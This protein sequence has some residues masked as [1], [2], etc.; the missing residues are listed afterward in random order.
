[1]NR[2]SRAG[3]KGDFVRPAILPDWWEDSCEQDPRLLPEIEIRIARFLGLP[4]L[5]VKDVN[6][7]LAPASYPAVQLRGARVTDPKRLGPAIHSA[8]RIAAAVVRN[9]RDT[10]SGPNVPPSNGL[11]W[12]DQ[13]SRDH[14]A[15]ALK[16]IVL[17]LWKRGIPVIPLEVLP[18]PSFQGIACIVEGRPCIVVGHKHDEPGRVA[19]LVA[20]EVGHIALGD[21][22]PDQPVVDEDVEIDLEVNIERCADD[23]AMQ[24]LIGDHSVPEISGFSFKDLAQEASKIEHENGADAS[25]VILAWARRTGDYQK[26]T[27]A[28]KALWRAAGA[29]KQLFEIFDQYVDIGTAPES[30][31]SLLRCVHGDS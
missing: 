14:Q 24:V 29:R 15:V 22:M 12:R 4:L 21:C 26:A 7:P 30:D 9:M 6:S 20:H 2:L 10:V 28:L 19:F 25:T 1:M 18:V 8:M 27:M 11:I 23:Y 16:D 3:F 31:Y 17:D 13:I 5:T